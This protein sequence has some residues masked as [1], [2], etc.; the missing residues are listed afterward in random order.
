MV[1]N[2][3]LENGKKQATN[4]SYVRLSGNT[5]SNHKEIELHAYQND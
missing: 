4:I 1:K 3:Q 5:D 2:I